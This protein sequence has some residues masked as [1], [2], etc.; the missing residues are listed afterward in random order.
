MTSD[1]VVVLE[2]VLAV[3]NSFL[4][5]LHTDLLQ[6]LMPSCQLIGMTHFATL[7]NS[8]KQQKHLQRD[9]NEYAPPLIVI[10]VLGEDDLVFKV[11]PA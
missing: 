4:S 11:L 1:Q 7:V 5:L 6:G 2:L 3:T 8:K 10:I 9:T